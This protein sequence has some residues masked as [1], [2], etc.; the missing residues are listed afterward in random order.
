TGRD[1]ELAA[2]AA[3]V[4][5]TSMA[6]VYS[7]PDMLWED[8]GALA[9]D[10]LDLGLH[11]AGVLG[12]TVLKMSIGLFNAGSRNTLPALAG[13]LPGQD[14]TLLIENDQTESAGS[15]PA[16]RDFFH[17]ADQAN[18]ALGMTFDMGNWHW[19]GECP[20]QAAQAFAAR[21]RYV[22]CKG[23]QRRP[24][25]WVAVPLT[26]SSAAWRALLRAMPCAA[27]RAIEYPLVGEDLL[28][29]T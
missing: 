27:P 26:E 25:R 14:I 1:D 13:R 8:Q 23:V 6:C 28:S 5:D 22:H 21:V 15:I 19:T 9:M 16:L 10:A 12:A 17:A 3:T 7:S 11:R 20:Q 29:V 2:L 24:D 18:L 4:R